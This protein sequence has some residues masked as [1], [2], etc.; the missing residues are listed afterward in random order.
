MG[1]TWCANNQRRLICQLGS[2]DSVSD[3][4]G[5]G[6]YQNLAGSAVE[7]YGGKW[8]VGQTWYSS[9]EYQAVKGRRQ[10]TTESS[11]VFVDGG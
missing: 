1:L 6:E 2:A 3:P 7:Q 10:A 4:E 11:V 9:P 8:I 5:L